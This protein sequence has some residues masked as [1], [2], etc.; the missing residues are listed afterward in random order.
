MPKK[1][2]KKVARR[3]NV[4]QSIRDALGELGI[5]AP[6]KDVAEAVAALSPEHQRKVEATGKLW[7]NY[8]SMQRTKLR[9]GP[10]RR[11]GGAAG[12]EDLT[13]TIRN[14]QDLIKVVAQLKS[15]SEIGNIVSAISGMGSPRKAQL[16]VQKFM[17][18]HKKY[19]DVRKV[20]AFLNDVESAGLK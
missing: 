4:S 1:T 19:D 5:D 14:L 20:E 16:V 8:V 7:D 13:V 15:P 11:R 3:V 9:G 12:G 18:L 6:A 17:D 10:K 2:T